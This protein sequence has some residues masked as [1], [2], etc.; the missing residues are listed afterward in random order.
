[1]A[2]VPTVKIVDP[3]NEDDFIIINESEF[4][5]AVHTMWEGEEAPAGTDEAEK[6]DIPLASMTRDRLVPRL[7]AVGGKLEDVEGTGSKGVVKNSDIADAIT[8]LEAA[9]AA[10][11]AEAEKAATE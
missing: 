11:E 7:E 3:R 5:P 6:Q 9:K 4:D 2:T 1:M 10:E 8:R